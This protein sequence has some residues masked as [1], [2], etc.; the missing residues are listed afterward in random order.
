MT[1]LGI[2][3]A[4]FSSLGLDVGCRKQIRKWLETTILDINV[5]KLV[6]TNDFVRIWS[7]IVDVFLVTL[8]SLF[9]VEI[10]LF[11]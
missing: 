3:E 1:L 2:Y 6:F 4:S 9:T 11:W 5:S 10:K 8:V 7:I